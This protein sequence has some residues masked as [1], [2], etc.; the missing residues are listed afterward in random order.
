VSLQVVAGPDTREFALAAL[1]FRL[2]TAT[3]CRRRANDAADQATTNGLPQRAAEARHHVHI[4]TRHID[5]LL[6]QRLTLTGTA[7]PPTAHAD[8]PHHRHGE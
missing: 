7:S 3:E 2:T 1:D 8:A 6:A 5:S 4:L